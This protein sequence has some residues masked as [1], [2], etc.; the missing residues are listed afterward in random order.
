[1]PQIVTY[2]TQ[3]IKRLCS[4]CTARKKSHAHKHAKHRNSKRVGKS[5]NQSHSL[6]MQMIM[7]PNNAKHQSGTTC[8]P[9]THP[10]T[11]SLFLLP[12]VWPSFTSTSTPVPQLCVPPTQALKVRFGN[13]KFNTYEKQ[14]K[15]S[16]RPHGSSTHLQALLTTLQCDGEEYRRLSCH[17][18]R[19]MGAVFTAQKMPRCETE[20]AVGEGRLAKSVTCHA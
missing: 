17:R 19:P 2:S 6:W 1:M 5:S 4:K 9:Q 16:Q 14:R 3:T 13:P 7:A 15:C 12:M 18:G 11:H 20:E 8:G 10:P